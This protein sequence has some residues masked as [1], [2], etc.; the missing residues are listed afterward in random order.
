MPKKGK[1]LDEMMDH[2]KVSS[3]EI[4]MDFLKGREMDE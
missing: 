4:G 2:R 3:M 1:Q